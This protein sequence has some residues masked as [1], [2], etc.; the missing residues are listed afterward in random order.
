ML[1][2]LLLPY[3]L[4][5]AVLACTAKSPTTDTAP[6]SSDGGAT[7]DG[8]T[9]TDGGANT[10]GGTNTDGG[11]G[12]TGDAVDPGPRPAHLVRFIAMGDGGEGN[13]DQYAVAATVARLCADKADAWG[14]GCDFVLYLGDNFYDDGVNSVDDDQFQSKFELPYASADLPF[15]VVLGNHD[16]GALSLTWWKGDYEVEYTDHSDKWIMPDS[17]YSFETEDVAF[18]GLD[19][20]AVLLDWSAAEQQAWLEGALA[21]STAKWKIVFGHHTYKSN[22]QHGS[23]GDYE[24]FEWLP[25]ANGANVQS[26]MDATLC[27]GVDLYL[28]GHDHTRQWL[29][30]VCGTELIVS[31]AA[32]KNTALVERGE[33]TFFEDD[34]TPGFVWIEIADDQLT[35]EMWTRDGDMDFTRTVHK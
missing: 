1:A 31:G 16:Y 30:P 12:D 3:V 17:Y 29:Q 24:G 4:A 21:A 18:F 6:G 19:T 20:N 34:S 8:A 26:F 14:P 25:I 5:C 22:G 32:S 15:Y 23:A 10:D 33:P 2:A 35:G 11:A 27:D 13:P 7:T 9:N 28:C